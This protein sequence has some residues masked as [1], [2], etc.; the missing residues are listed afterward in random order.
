MRLAL[1]AGRGRLVRQLLVESLRARRWR[2]GR[3][4]SLV[5]AWTGNAA[6]RALPFEEAARDAPRRPRPARRPASPSALASLTGVVFGS[7]P[8]CS[9]RG[10]TLA[11]TLKNE[12]ARSSGGAAPFRFRKGLVVAQVALSLL[13]LVGAGLFTRSLQNLRALDP[14][15]QPERLLT[16]S[17]DPSLNG[18]DVPRRWPSSSESGRSS[19]RSRACSRSPWP[20]WPCMTDSD[21]EQHRAAS[22][23]Y[24]RRKTRT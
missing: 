18:Y 8:R 11:P 23:G 3:W 9:R 10:S 1:G 15:F 19:P 24:S 7:S 14:G 13:L 21:N 2:A 20:T 5:A 4:A 16:F 12:T 22:T 17:V 6:L